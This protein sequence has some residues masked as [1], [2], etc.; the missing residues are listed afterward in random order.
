MPVRLLLERDNDTAV[1][2]KQHTM[3][4]ESEGMQKEAIEIQ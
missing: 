1:H 2:S 4:H 3:Q